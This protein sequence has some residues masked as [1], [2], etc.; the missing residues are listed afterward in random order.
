MRKAVA[1]KLTVTKGKVSKKW[2]KYRTKKRKIKALKTLD[3]GQKKMRIANELDKTITEISGEWSQYREVKH[4]IIHKSPFADFVYV[5]KMTGSKF[6]P[7]GVLKKAEYFPFT[8]HYQK[9]Y[10]AKKGFDVEKL[11]EIVP[12]IL[13]QKRVSGVLVVYQIVSAESGQQ[14]FVSN[15]ITKDVMDK[16]EENEETV[17]EYISNRFSA[18]STKDYKLKFVYMRI[19]YAKA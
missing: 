7:R 14:Q 3:V 8:D 17:N 11:N 15:Y 10:K 18:G 2:G 19:V 4:A 16:I 12:K 13:E 6:N 1:K 5:K 9:I